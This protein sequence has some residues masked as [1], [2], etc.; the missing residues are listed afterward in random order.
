LVDIDSLATVPETLAKISVTANF[1][2]ELVL[3][4]QE[5]ILSL[6]QMTGTYG[7]VIILRLCVS[8]C[9]LCGA[10]T[11]AHHTVVERMTLN[12]VTSVII[13]F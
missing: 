11:V 12:D 5:V 8:A 4:I 7:N 13:S 1:L 3:R 6:G 10:F 9:E 2:V